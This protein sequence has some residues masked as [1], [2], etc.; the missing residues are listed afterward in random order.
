LGLVFFFFFFFETRSHIYLGWPPTCSHLFV[1][2]MFNILALMLKHTITV[3]H[4]YFAVE[5]P[6]PSLPIPLHPVPTNILPLF[7]C[8][9]SILALVPTSLQEIETIVG[10]STVIRP[11]HTFQVDTGSGGGEMFASVCLASGQGGKRTLL[12]Q[13]Y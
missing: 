10:N 8:I 6:F 5:I 11:S 2:R 1:L 9:L 12:S 4:H 3:T 13:R 7:S